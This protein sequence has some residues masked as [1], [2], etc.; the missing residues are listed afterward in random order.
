MG[1]HALRVVARSLHKRV[2]RPAD[3]AARYGGEEFVLVMPDTPLDGALVPKI[4]TASELKHLHVANNR[5][6]SME[7]DSFPPGLLDGGDVDFSNNTISIWSINCGVG[8]LGFDT[9]P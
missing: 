2:Q 4:A 6:I 5:I 7:P 8:K 9:C 3:L 1:D